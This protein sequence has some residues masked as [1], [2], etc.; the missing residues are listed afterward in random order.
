MDFYRMMITRYLL[1]IWRSRKDDFFCKLANVHS[2]HGLILVVN[3]GV[4]FRSN[5][6]VFLRL[7]KVK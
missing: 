1:I 2:I 6:Y 4:K 7:N 5:N 3:D